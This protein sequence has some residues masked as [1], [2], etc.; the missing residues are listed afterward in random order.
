VLRPLFAPGRIEIVSLIAYVAS[1]GASFVTDAAFTID[2]G[3]L[4]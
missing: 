4:G 3:Y 2:G 1:A